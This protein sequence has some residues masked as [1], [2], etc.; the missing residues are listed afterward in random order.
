MSIISNAAN[1]YMKREK[2]IAK[3]G[4]LQKRATQTKITRKVWQTAVW[5]KSRQHWLSVCTLYWK[6]SGKIW[7]CRIQAWVLSEDNKFS[8]NECIW[9]FRQHDLNLFV[10]TDTLTLKCSF[11]SE[12]MQYFDGVKSCIFYRKAMLNVRKNK[13]RN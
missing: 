7:L 13:K 10:Q 8:M 12:N 4:L 9:D 2:K 5:F 6:C 1:Y 3:S 11:V